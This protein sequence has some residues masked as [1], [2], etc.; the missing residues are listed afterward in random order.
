MKPLKLLFLLLFFIVSIDYCFSDNDKVN[1]TIYILDI[2]KDSTIHFSEEENRQLYDSVKKAIGY[3]DEI[4]P[5]QYDQV[6][7]RVFGYL[8]REG[9]LDSLSLRARSSHCDDYVMA[10]NKFFKFIDKIELRG[11]PLSNKKRSIFFFIH[12]W[13]E[14]GNFRLRGMVF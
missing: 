5:G 2:R 10:L 3:K 4:E 11:I 14:V 12:M 7:I 8:S 1:K 6:D 13:Q 9:K